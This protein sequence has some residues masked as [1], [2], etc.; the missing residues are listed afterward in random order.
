MIEKSIVLVGA[1]NA[2]LV[3]LR[4][5][6][7]RPQPGL[8][9]TLVNPTAAVPYSA[10]VP[11]HIAG[12]SGHKEITI[13]LVRLCAT[14]GVRLITE[15]VTALDPAAREVQFA[16]RP[17]LRYDALSL[18]LGSVPP[19][20]SRHP[21]TT[22]TVSLRPLSLLIQRID[23]WEAELKQ[24]PKPFHLAIVGG[25][26][27]GCELA[28]AIHN[29]LGSYSSFHITVFQSADRL[30]P[31]FPRSTTRAFESVFQSRG[32]E[33]RLNAR[34]SGRA[35]DQ[36]SL[37]SGES[38]PCDAVLWATP[39]APD[40]LIQSSGL[41][42]N[43]DG[44]L[45]VRT[46][47]QSESH[48]EI[49]GTG[50]CVSF[51]EYPDLA[52]SGVHA[53]RQ[54][55][56]L[57]DNLLSFVHE[58]SLKPF[59]PQRRCLYL[60][61]A[62]DGTA[63]LNY[64]P[65]GWNAR[66]VRNWKMRIDRRWLQSF[67]PMRMDASSEA[68]PA[69]RCGGCGSKISGDVLSTVLQQLN[70]QPHPQ[71]YV[72]VREGEDAAVLRLT[73]HGPAVVQTVDFF[74]SF[75]DDPYLFGR[76]AALHALSDLYAMNAQPVAALAIA[77]LPHARGPIQEAMLR[78]LLSGALRTFADHNVAL[79]GGHTT[80]AAELAVGF[81]ITGTANEQQ[82]FRKAALQPGDRLILTKPIG[83][84][85]LLAA[86]MR[87]ACRAP[88]WNELIASLLQSNRAA[89]EILARH[90][91]RAC[92]DVTGFGLAGH[93][94]EMLDASRIGVSLYKNAIPLLNGFR[95]VVDQGVVSTLHADNAK[96]ACRIEGESQ[97]AW[98]FDPQT[99]G[100]LLAG[101][102]AEKVATVLADLHAAGYEHAAVVGEVETH[103]ET[104]ILVI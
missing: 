55:T 10:M 37:E 7:M 22:K 42:T 18:G 64:G 80:E 88:W 27:S 47:L 89:A 14:A 70:L 53:V 94:F 39:G 73:E 24:T 21:D 35:D 45:R 57:F 46:T 97:A 69:M 9:V 17:P 79:A 99:S 36:L 49:F 28:L 44:F 52:R 101:V 95:E 23:A 34:V 86:A 85:V 2:H 56:V 92:T 62:G 60:L 96:I 40:P 50:D 1:G 103:I 8:M 43:N 11:A 93:L 91:I 26:A 77:T 58:R 84:G 19:I 78:E 3:F 25:G 63:I 61:N 51:A 90:G 102:P 41:S 67:E 72:G 98:L 20:L 87:G 71:V 100:G 4:K 33:V 66:W 32:I 81:A 76:V 82:L 54:G 74:R 12:E 5:W 6:R 48:P 83:T 29:R 68:A 38:I 59:Q 30:V 13:D 75:T 31:R 15:A 16:D 65:I 104:R